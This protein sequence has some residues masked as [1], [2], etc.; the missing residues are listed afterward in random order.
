[1]RS[2]ERELL[3]NADRKQ[4][5]YRPEK[6]RPPCPSGNQQGPAVD[7]RMPERNDN[8]AVEQYERLLKQ[9]ETCP[10]RGGKTARQQNSAAP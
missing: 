1:M 3:K 6:G 9:I 5:Q 8:Q 4:R 2:I 7:W 10:R